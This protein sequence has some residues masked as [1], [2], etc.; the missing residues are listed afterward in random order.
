MV[1]GTK[2]F[3]V[4]FVGGWALVLCAQPMHAG[5]QRKVQGAAL[6]ADKGCA[7]CH[8]PSGFGGSDSGP[9]LSRVRK[10]LKPDEI[11]H[12]IHDGGKNMPPF[13]DTLSEDEI[14]SLVDYLHS[15]RKPPPGYVRK[16]PIAPISTPAT[17][18]GSDPG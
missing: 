5:D 3:S 9:D 14:K 10:E 8:G 17:R 18:Q 15:K 2:Y 13:G 4:R 1:F 6:F 12:Q 16:A 7:H 11:A